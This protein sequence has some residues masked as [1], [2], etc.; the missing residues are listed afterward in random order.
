LYCAKFVE[1]Q[2][3]GKGIKSQEFLLCPPIYADKPVA[4]F[5]MRNRKATGMKTQKN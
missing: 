5:G 3:Y 2:K 1:Y 4:S